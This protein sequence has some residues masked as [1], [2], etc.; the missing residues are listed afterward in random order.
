MNQ[1]KYLLLIPVLA[2]MLFYISCTEND[3][4]NNAKTEVTAKKEYQKRYLD[5]GGEIKQGVSNKKTYLDFYLGREHDFGK[6]VSYDELNTYEREEFDEAL[7]R[8][9]S[10]Q[11]S[12]YSILKTLKIYQQEDGRKILAVITKH[13][14]DIKL[15]IVKRDSLS[16]GSYS[17]LHVN[18]RP[19]FPGCEERDTD[20]LFKKIDEHFQSNFDKN[21]PNNLGL[22]SGRKKAY[23]SFNIDLNGYVSDIKVRAPHKEIEKEVTK[24]IGSLPKMSSGTYKDKPVKVRFTLPFVFFVD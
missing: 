21:L 20:C 9:K 22:S 4:D 10:S 23:V 19:I 15:P 7:E 13:P 12:E 6:E 11:N 24:V 5:L 8:F 14:K 16:D 17:I 2:S 18:K 1:L 3:F